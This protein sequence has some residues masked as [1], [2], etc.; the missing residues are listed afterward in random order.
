M[1]VNE[2]VG[3]G[4]L[5]NAKVIAGEGGLERSLD[6]ISVLEVAESTI[7][8][9][10]IKNQ[11][12]ITSFYAIK[13]DVKMQKIVIETLNKSGCCGLVL[14][15]LKMILGTVSEEIIEVCN[16][17]DFP[18]IV[19]ETQVS[20]IE[21]L[22]PIIAKLSEPEKEKAKTEFLD[23]LL[24]EKELPE[25]LEKLSF[26]VGYE[27]S[28][29]DVQCNCLYS[30]KGDLEREEERKFLR[31]YIPWKNKKFGVLKYEIVEQFMPKKTMLYYIK[32]K[33]NF[34]GVMMI[35]Y[36]DEESTEKIL[37][38][39][40]SMNLICALLFSRKQ[41]IHNVEDN[42]RQEYISDLLVWNFRDTEVAVRRGHELGMPME[43]K[44][45]ILVININAIQKIKDEKAAG[46]L[47]HYV[48]HWFMPHIS[49]YAR[50]Y[51]DN[52]I[53]YYRSDVV[54]LFLPKEKKR[55]DMSLLAQKLSALFENNTR[56][57]ISIGISN[58]ISAIEGI[59]G[60]YNEAFDSA[61]MGREYCGEN[62]VI[63]YKDIWFLHYIKKMKNQPEAEKM[64][65]EILEPLYE[66]DKSKGTELIYTLKIL[67]QCR[68]EQKEA[69][70]RLYI[71]RNTMLYRKK[72]IVDIL[73]YPAFEL[74]YLFNLTAAMIIKEY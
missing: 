7:S 39:A 11:L 50:S 54:L 13:D 3:W 59:P 73:G 43:D 34:F 2:I 57:S 60:A 17:L 38:I 6:S 5:K 72:Q 18:L 20:Y 19:A 25:I 44:R 12:Y 30:N 48:R 33:K 42:Y 47:Q 16:E 27:I 35:S 24:E 62:K 14:C 21:I 63:Y 32:S 8:T 36:P 31:E 65:A 26:D 51:G 69:A 53:V 37:D 74:P 52:S 10:V 61:I 46:E 29:F 58:E 55:E 49:E 41:R 4:G 71:H 28:F 45:Y 66:F 70:E 56:T 40:N 22:N 64:A 67:L 23:L 15:H 9:W 68:L 1:R